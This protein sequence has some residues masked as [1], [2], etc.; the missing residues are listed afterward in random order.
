MHNV[1]VD[2]STNKVKCRHAIKLSPC[3][4]ITLAG[5]GKEDNNIPAPTVSQLGEQLKAAT[6]NHNT[7]TWP[8]AAATWIGLIPIAINTLHIELVCAD[9]V[10]QLVGLICSW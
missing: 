4:H 8:V 6:S 1:K 7:S 3:I 5:S 2:L 9:E 10:Q